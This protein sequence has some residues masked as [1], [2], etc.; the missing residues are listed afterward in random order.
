VERLGAALLVSIFNESHCRV[1]AIGFF[2]AHDVPAI[3]FSPLCIL[4]FSSK[5]LASALL[6]QEIEEK[7]GSNSRGDDS[8][9]EFRGE[10]GSREEVTIEEKDAPGQRGLRKE[11]AMVGTDEQPDPMGDD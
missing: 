2:S 4:R 11:A 9:G 3:T 1:P 7:R 5:G 10:D 8:D 6:M